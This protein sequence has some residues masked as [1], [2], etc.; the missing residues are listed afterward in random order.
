MKGQIL[1]YHYFKNTDLDEFGTL[2]SEKIAEFQEE[3]LEVEVSHHALTD[4]DHAVHIAY[5]YG[6]S[7]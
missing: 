2:V 1:S 6:R 7:R 4:G 3:N 5:I